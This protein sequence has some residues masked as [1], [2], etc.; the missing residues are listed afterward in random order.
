[1][2]TS[3][4]A[5]ARAATVASVLLAVLALSSCGSARRSE[6]VTGPMKMEEESVRRGKLLYD[7]HCYKC[8]VQGEGGM[9]PALN[10]KPLPRFLM[11]FQS[12]HGLGAM[13]AFSEKE[14]SDR[15]LEDILNYLV[16]LRRHG[17]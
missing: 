5:C 12:R 14:I 13:P 16:A 4:P 3:C 17:K 7:A 9:A 1:M 2:K 10:D 11:H 6:P 15:E 8:H